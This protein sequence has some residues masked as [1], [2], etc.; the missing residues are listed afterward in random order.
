MIIAYEHKQEQNQSQSDQLQAVMIDTDKRII[1]IQRIK[2]VGGKIVGSV[3][4]KYCM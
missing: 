2:M 1:A 3:T 4:V